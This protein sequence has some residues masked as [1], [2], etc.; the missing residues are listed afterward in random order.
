MAPPVRRQDPITAVT[1]GVAAFLAPYFPPEKWGGEPPRVI[2]LPLTSTM[3][4]KIADATPRLYIGFAGAD[5][6]APSGRGFV[7]TFTFSLFIVM[8]GAA[9]AGIQLGD[10]FSPG[11]YASL[12]AAVAALH[13]RTIADV[14]TIEVTKVAE[15]PAEGWSGFG[16][17]AGYV[18]FT[19]QSS[20]GDF[21]GE[22]AAAAEFR[23]MVASFEINPESDPDAPP[24]D[25]ADTPIL[26]SGAQP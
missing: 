14:G 17:A 4:G 23:E 12:I 9:K 13:G 6:K 10:R 5:P 18:T 8:K 22:G 7:G 19:V 11:L 21:L 16:A 25:G 24:A 15:Q 20:L 26:L 1:H 2:G 3:F